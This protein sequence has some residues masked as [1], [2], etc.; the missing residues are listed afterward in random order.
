MRTTGEENTVGAVVLELN[1][2]DNTRRQIDDAAKQVNQ[3]LGQAFHGMEGKISSSFSKPLENAR[4]RMNS[5]SRQMDTVAAKIGALEHRKFIGPGTQ[6]EIDKLI[7]QSDMLVEKYRAAEEKVAV[8]ARAVA[9]KQAETAKKAQEKAAAAAQKAQERIR[10]EQEK[11]AKQAASAAKKMENKVSVS[12][13]G[14]KNGVTRSLKT[15]AGA[16]KATFVTAALY[17]FFKG[18]K[19]LLSGASAQSDQFT[20]SMQQIKDNLSTA[21]MP[22]MDAAMP[23]LNMLISGLA[24]ATRYVAAFMAG[25]FGKTYSQMSK[26]SDKIKATTGAAAKAAG[27][28]ASFDEINV[29][30]RGGGEAEGGASGIT[31]EDIAQADSFSERITGMLDGIKE[32]VKSTMPQVIS[33]LLSFIAPVDEGGRMFRERCGSEV[34]QFVEDQ[35]Q[36][37]TKIFSNWKESVLL[38]SGD[39]GEFLSKFWEDNSIYISR[40]VDGAVNGFWEFANPIIDF[41]TGMWYDISSAVREFAEDPALQDFFTAVNELLVAC[42]PAWNAFVDTI[43]MLQQWIGGGLNVALSGLRGYLNGIWQFIKTFLIVAITN[44][45]NV[46]RVVTALLNGDWQKAWELAKTG[47]T[48]AIKGIINMFVSFVNI[49]TSGVNGIIN[50]LKKIEIDIPDWVPVFGGKEFAPFKGLPTIPE[51]PAVAFANGGVIDQPTLALMGEYAGAGSNPEI[52]APQGIMAETFA[53]SLWPLIDAIDDLK[54]AVIAAIL[55]KDTT[56]ELDGTELG[57]LLKKYIDRENERTG[58]KLVKG[59][60]Y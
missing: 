55:S 27:A 21:F 25:L 37:A 50:G 47:A 36:R 23:L 58:P 48:D 3:K 9:E 16:F 10:K 45:T 52:V 35:K 1:I 59:G 42:Q 4:A 22:I 34:D 33:G 40:W 51:L 28:L 15:V 39:I 2:K 49:F 38:I 54:E 12:M 53:E 24:T 20:K 17:T 56:I 26:A 29:L 41:F 11:T 60:A 7:A 32:K 57:R 43:I 46:I 19:S 14:I 44:L 5:I 8:E 6:K 31:Q 13:S 30:D 18:F